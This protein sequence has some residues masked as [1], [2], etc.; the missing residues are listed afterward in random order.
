MDAMYVDA[1]GRSP[2]PHGNE[3]MR[4]DTQ[5]LKFDVRK[6]QAAPE[7][8]DIDAS[9]SVKRGAGDFA[10]GPTYGPAGAPPPMIAPQSEP[11]VPTTLRDLESASSAAGEQQA[12]DGA[13]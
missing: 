4:M 5:D 11:R 12:Q 8:M 7:Y 6:A 3:A 9:A 1:A 13:S 2:P 10:Q